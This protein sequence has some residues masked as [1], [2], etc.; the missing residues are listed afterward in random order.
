MF[1]LKEVPERPKKML[2]VAKKKEKRRDN[3]QP[4]F[5]ERVPGRQPK[6]R[7]GE[8]TCGRPAS[9]GEIKSFSV[10]YF[11]CAITEILAGPSQVYS[12]AS[13]PNASHFLIMGMSLLP[14][15]QYKTLV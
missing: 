3:N 8:S 5:I 12:Q 15:S 7:G 9:A 4:F 2:E 1:G 13:A 11:A 14:A 10:W 6:L